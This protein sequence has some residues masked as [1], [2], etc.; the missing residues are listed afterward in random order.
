MGDDCMAL[1]NDTKE[2]NGNGSMRQLEDGTFE[3]VIQSKYINPKTGKPKRIKRRGK[4]ESE[5]REKTQMAL[6]AWEKEIE[7]GRDTKVNRAKTFGQYMEEYIDTEAKPTL[8]GSGYH[9][10]ISNMKNNFYPFSIS[11]L[12]LHMLSAVEFEHYF[13]SI[14]ELKSRKTCSLP[15]QLCR[16]CCKWLVDKS[17]LKEN[18]AAQAKIKREISD[19]YDKKREDDIKNRKKVFSSEDIEKFYYAYKNNMGQYPVVVLFLLETGLRAGEFSALRNDSIDLEN[20]K[21]HIVETQSLRFKDNDKTKGVE[22]YVKV[23]KNKEARFIMMSDL[24]RECVIYMME[25]TKLNC[26]NNLDN[27]LYP[28]FINGK[29]RSNS[30]MEVCFKELCDKLG[31]DRD[32]HLTK[33]GQKKGLCL[34]SLRHTA[35]TIANTAKGAN[36]VNTALM[37]GHKAVSVENIYTHA[38]EEGL[39]SVVTPSQAVLSDY[40][41][42]DQ[43]IPEELKDMSPEEI[44]EMYQMY[45]KLKGIFEK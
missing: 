12:Q 20:N 8:T 14:L 28:T 1:K 10:Y 3:C 25:Q 36:V 40:K 32:V 18:Y 4:T 45:Q 2:Q 19:E 15:L 16:R 27:L 41:K 37:M 42:D 38:T 6:S 39:S 11:K 30:S 33:T 17:L 24:C 31:I 35:D 5:T 44:Q 22:Y 34:H 21:I 29:R 26:K 23:P 43:K 9:S 7:R 13:D